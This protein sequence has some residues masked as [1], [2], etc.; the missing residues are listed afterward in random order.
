MSVSLESVML[1]REMRQELQEERAEK[2]KKK[3]V[4]FGLP[5]DEDAEGDG[6]IGGGPVSSMKGIDGVQRLKES[7]RRSP[8]KFAQSIETKMARIIDEYPG[9]VGSTSKHM[10]AVKYVASFMG[11][12][13]QQAVGRLAYALGQIHRA[14]SKGELAEA[15]FLVLI[16]IA[17]CC[18]QC[19]DGNWHVAWDLT[20]F[21]QPPWEV[22][23]HRDLGEL[24][25]S[26]PFCPLFESAWVS[27]VSNKVREEEV[28]L[29]KRSPHKAFD[30]ADKPGKGGGKDGGG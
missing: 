6:E 8:E 13:T 28:L 9:E 3:Q 18:Q 30:K 16:S 21:A 11:V 4:V 25:K 27:L 26:Y 22:W 29:K 24:R 14:L 15:R 5:G 12:G 1:I 10:V 7:F 20:P 19:L 23:K 2:A 17:A